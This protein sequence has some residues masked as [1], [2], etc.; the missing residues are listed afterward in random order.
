M[1]TLPR[2]PIHLDENGR[3]DD[4]FLV[5]CLQKPCTRVMVLVRAIH[6]RVKGAGIAD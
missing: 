1:E 2:K 3:G 4:H 5:D 6:G